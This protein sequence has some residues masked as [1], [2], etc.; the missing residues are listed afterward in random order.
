LDEVFSVS[1]GCSRLGGQP[2]VIEAGRTLLPIEVKA[3]AT[4]RVSDAKH[5]RVFREEYGRR[6]RPGLVLHT[7]DAIE[8]LAPGILA[9]PWWKVL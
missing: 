4:P 1:R 3:T 8:W 9:A 2:P 6:C 5:L 7:G